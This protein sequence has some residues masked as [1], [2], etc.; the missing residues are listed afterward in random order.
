MPRKLPNKQKRKTN[1]KYCVDTRPQPPTSKED[2]SNEELILAMAE[3]KKKEK[4]LMIELKLQ[5]KIYDRLMQ[6]ISTIIEQGRLLTTVLE[7]KL[8]LKQDDVKGS[9][10]R[11][12]T[13]ETWGTAST[14]GLVF[15]V[16]AE[17]EVWAKYIVRQ[18][19]DSNGRENHR[20]DKIYALESNDMREVVNVGAKLIDA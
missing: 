9:R 13:V 15:T 8:S 16:M 4:S 3:L 7:K 10:Y 19:L 18:W 6:K 12:F 5:R 1:Q 14:D 2:V 17:N 11:L 20:I